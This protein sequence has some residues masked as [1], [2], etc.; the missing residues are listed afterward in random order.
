MGKVKKT[1]QSTKQRMGP[2]AA[3]APWVLGILREG[4]GER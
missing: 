1:S 3:A 4:V 2:S